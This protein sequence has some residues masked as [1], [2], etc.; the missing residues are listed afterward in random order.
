MVS[1]LCRELVLRKHYLPEGIR[2]ET[3][4]FGG[5]TPSLLDISELQAILNTIYTHYHVADD[6]EITLEANPDDLSLSK[7]KALSETPVNRLSIGIQS[8][9][10][11][12]LRW[13]NRAHSASEAKSVLTNAQNM[14]FENLTADLIYGYPLLTDEKWKANIDYLLQSGIRHLSAYSMTVE[15]GTP[16]WRYI[17]KGQQKAMDDEQSARQFLFLMAE[18]QTNGWEQYEISNFALNQSYSRHNTNYWRNVPYLGIGPSAHSFDG[19]SRQWNTKINNRYIQGI[20][21]GNPVFEK[22]ILSLSNQVNEYL[23]T[24]LRTMWGVDLVLI[25]QKFGH[26]VRVAILKSSQ[27]FIAQKQLILQDEKLILSQSGKL[28]ADHI[29][30]EL[31]L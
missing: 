20:A 5:G 17:H 14:G 25:G 21:A 24:A 13:M 29:A 31:F 7:L 1:A 19:Q 8:F 4:Y 15:K 3:I 18:L 28:F 12:D 11:E 27:P 2:I 23:M 16:L 22:E 6:A 30:A 9:F 26:A 10:E